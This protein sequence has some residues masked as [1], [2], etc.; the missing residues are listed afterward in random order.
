[1]R[2]VSKTL[3]RQVGL[4]FSHLPCFL[5]SPFLRGP[6]S[7]EFP[8]H[9]HT[10]N[11]AR[12]GIGFFLCWAVLAMPGLAQQFSGQGTRQTPAT[13]PGSM[14]PS[15]VDPFAAFQEDWSSPS[16]AGSTL[17][18]LPPVV[19]ERDNYPDFTREIVE[20]QWRPG[21]P[22]YLYVMLPKQVKHPPGILYLY[23][24]PSE[25]DRF[26]D[27]EFCKLLIKNGTAAIGFVSALTS[28]RYHDRPMK[29]W[30]ISELEES[31]ATSVHDVQMILN[32]LASRGDIDMDRIGMF[33]D[34]SG[35]AITILT[36]AVD[37]RIKVL[38][39][40]EPW[41]DWPDWLAK[42]VLV[43][44][45]ERAAYLTPEFLQRVEPLDPLKWLSRLS[46]RTVRLQ[47]APYET[48]TP[49]SA[50]ARLEKAMPAN[51][52]MVRYE[53]SKAL[54]RAASSGQ[55]FDWIQVQVRASAG[56]TTAVLKHQAT[57]RE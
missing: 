53:T 39:L 2:R 32:Y 52:E 27:Q 18:A 21:D 16:L 57:R 6:K 48:L 34:G 17:N 33:G 49:S 19:G 10:A 25:T 44:D 45:E 7:K 29:E 47:L 1:M 36:A 23:T 15:G 40:L 35:G 14:G 5:P 28:Q 13:R 30:F 56:R 50:R 24:Y 12:A 38:D 55:F 3:A 37:A 51:V 54:L 31:L 42:S 43:P 8:L 26:R 41:G 22:I 4:N 9:R 11:F 46:S 20:V